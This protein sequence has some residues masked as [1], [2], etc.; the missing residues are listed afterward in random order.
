MLQADV[1]AALF[2][3]ETDAGGRSHVRLLRLLRVVDLGRLLHKVRGGNSL[4]GHHLVHRAS[5]LHLLRTARLLHLLLLLERLAVLSEQILDRDQVLLL[6]WLHL[7]VI[8]LLDHRLR[9]S[10]LVDCG[11]GGTLQGIDRS[12]RSDL[13]LWL[14]HLVGT[15]HS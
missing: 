4:L 10:E 9:R 12:I 6:L 15:R 11:H 13:Q 7:W 1:L 5:L 8:V 14:R 3:L 2:L